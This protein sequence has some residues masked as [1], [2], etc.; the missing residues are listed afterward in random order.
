M[1]T[2]MRMRLRS[3]RTPSDG[4]RGDGGLDRRA[5]TFA[6]V[7]ARRGVQDDQRTGLR[8]QFFLSDHEFAG[9]H[10]RRPV[11]LA[12][13]IALVVAAQRVELVPAA[14]HRRV[15]HDA[16]ALHRRREDGYVL[17]RGV[18]EE[19][20]RARDLLA[21]PRRSERIGVRDL[22]GSD[23]MPS[24][25]SWLRRCT[26]P[27]ADGDASHRGAPGA[28]TVRPAAAACLRAAPGRGRA[29]RSTST[30]SSTRAFPPT[31]VR[32]GI[33]GPV[34]L[35]AALA[36]PHECDAGDQHESER[37]AGHD[38]LAQS[39]DAPE[40]QHRQRRAREASCLSSS[41]RD[42]SFLRDG[43]RV[44]DVGDERLRVDTRE[45]RFRCGDDPMRQAQRPR[46]P[47]RRRGRRSHAHRQQR[48]RAQ[49]V[50]ASGLRA[51]TRR[52]TSD[53]ARAFPSAARRCTT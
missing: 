49:R 17:E 6:A 41:R 4:A 18:D 53:R 38:E 36:E 28:G 13:V 15:A 32:G 1:T 34:D 3:A 7:L 42:A 40:D 25:Q 20:R 14:D 22:E 23:R 5:R 33:D 45:L 2:S 24:P 19:R 27:H 21:A 39:A 43:R 30:R 31:V 10:A 46:G 11:D 47:S 37:G 44:D 48:A 35:D 29:G 50:A 9:A 16:D 26:R 12:Q 8:E 51:V 52:G